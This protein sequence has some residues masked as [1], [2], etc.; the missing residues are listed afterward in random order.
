M[1]MT[2]SLPIG[3]R[4]LLGD[5]HPSFLVGQRHTDPKE[6]HQPEGPWAPSWQEVELE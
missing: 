6:K 5:I 2:W 1:G 4:P 3:I